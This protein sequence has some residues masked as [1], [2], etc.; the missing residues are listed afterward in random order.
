MEKLGESPINYWSDLFIVCMVL[1]W[2][3]GIVIMI[4]MAIYMSLM[5]QD[6][7]LWT[8]VAEL[9]GAPVTAGGALW[10]IKNGVQHAIVNRTG[11][12]CK[13]DFPK[14]YAPDDGMERET[15]DSKHL[16]SKDSEVQETETVN[17]EELDDPVYTEEDFF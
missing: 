13:Y 5:Y 9:I 8:N 14:V 4:G 12:E 7:S 2:I 15:D 17:E 10:M 3:V 16:V 1:L 11:K 6:T